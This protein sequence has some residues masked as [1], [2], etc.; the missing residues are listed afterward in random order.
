MGQ[1]WHL[2]VRGVRGSFPRPDPKDPFGGNTSCFYLPCGDTGIV[3]DAGSGLSALGH[4]MQE[5]PSL[6]RICILL[7]HFHL[8]HI[9]GLFSF[10]PF[11]DPARDIRIYGPPGVRQTLE[12]LVRPP[13]WPV[14]FSDFSASV[15]FYDVAPGVDYDL[16][17]ARMTALAGLHP[18]GCLYYRLDGPDG[19]RLV[20]AL[21]CEPDGGLLTSLGVFARHCGLLVWDAHFAPGMVRPGWGHSTWEQ[22]LEAARLAG[23]QRV[24][25]THFNNNYD[26]Q[27]LLRQEE[28]ARRRDAR[29]V[30]AREGMVIA[31]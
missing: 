18:G 29:C 3:L 11:F 31:V 1:D 7:T 13:Y 14:T 9:L 10:A 28:L 21:D 27:F 23:A 8:D 22:G 16:G 6:R 5:N 25:M 12:A 24:L 20:Y 30:F 4:D 17:G 2:E 26:G 19:K 15:S